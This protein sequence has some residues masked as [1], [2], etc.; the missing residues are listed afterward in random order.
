M[1]KK[2][3]LLRFWLLGIFVI[4]AAALFILFWFIVTAAS[5]V[6]KVGVSIGQV[7]LVVWPYWLGMAVLFVVVYFIYRA[8]VTRKK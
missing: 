1:E 7:F 5:A 8:L 2:L 4:L 3:K 6:A